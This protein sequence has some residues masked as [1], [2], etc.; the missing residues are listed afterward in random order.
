VTYR[1]CGTGS[2][3]G[4][5]SINIE[6]EAFWAGERSSVCFRVRSGERSFKCYVS[7]EALDDHFGGDGAKDY[8]AVL[9]RNHDAILAVT[10]KVID[11]NKG[12][13]ENEVVIETKFFD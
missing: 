7:Q 11:A 8:V 6:G 5:M 12:A 4:D 9:L 13:S 2:G 10:E 1:E 3:K